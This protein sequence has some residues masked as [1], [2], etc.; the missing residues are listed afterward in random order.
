MFLWLK[1]TRGRPSQ[2]GPKIQ[3]IFYFFSKKK[4]CELSQIFT[5]IDQVNL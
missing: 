1:L 2:N 5:K 4:G 3:K